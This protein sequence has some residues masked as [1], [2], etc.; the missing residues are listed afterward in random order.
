MEGKSVYQTLEKSTTYEHRAM[1]G[2][3]VTASTCGPRLPSRWQ[4]YGL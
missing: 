3:H 1:V 4:Q 2:L